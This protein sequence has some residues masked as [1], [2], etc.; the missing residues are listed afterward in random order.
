MLIPVRRLDGT[1]LGSRYCWP[2]VGRYYWP[3]VG[4]RLWTDDKDGEPSSEAPYGRRGPLTIFESQDAQYL[5]YREDSWAPI[6]EDRHHG[7]IISLI[8]ST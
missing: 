8:Y 1:T 4:K 3:S 2:S 7:R 6:A 5:Q